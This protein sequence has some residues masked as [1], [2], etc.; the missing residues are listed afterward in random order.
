MSLLD[1]PG[2]DHQRIKLQP[3]PNPRP[4]NNPKAVS[5]VGFF[6]PSHFERSVSPLNGQI[7][8]KSGTFKYDSQEQGP[9][10]SSLWCDQ[11]FIPLVEPAS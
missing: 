9:C 7:L 3:G 5:T 1:D 6:P 4:G 2:C 10:I 11:P 8:Q